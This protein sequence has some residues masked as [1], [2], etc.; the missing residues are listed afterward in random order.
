MLIKF[1]KK[2][3][4]CSDTDVQDRAVRNYKLEFQLAEK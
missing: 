2:E 1:G 4:T 3:S